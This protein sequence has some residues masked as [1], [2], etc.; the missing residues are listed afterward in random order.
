MKRE[1]LQARVSTISQSIKDADQKVRN[2]DQLIQSASQ[3]LD[4]AAE[5]ATK[6][7][8]NAAIERLKEAVDAIG[9]LRVE[10]APAAD[11]PA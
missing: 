6:V 3:A 2:A 7:L 1:E 8:L 11:P 5:V 10:P 4:T 9:Q